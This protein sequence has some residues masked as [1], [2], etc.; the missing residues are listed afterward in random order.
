[1][2]AVVD[3]DGVETV[4]E[5]RGMLMELASKGKRRKREDGLGLGQKGR[6]SQ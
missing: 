3:A 5:V 1:M 6:N 2:G 4:Q